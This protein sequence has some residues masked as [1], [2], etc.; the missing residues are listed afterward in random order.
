VG[1]GGRIVAVAVGLDPH[2]EREDVLI[3]GAE[4]LGAAIVTD[5]TSAPGTNSPT[6]S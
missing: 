1:S 2:V 3:G 4:L 6:Q 5:T